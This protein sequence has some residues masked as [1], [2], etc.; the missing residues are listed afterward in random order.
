[1]VTKKPGILEILKV[2]GLIV[3]A[4]SSIIVAYRAIESIPEKAA[5][6]TME[7]VQDI[8][9]SV[10]ELKALIE[11]NA[12]DNKEYHEQM[13]LILTEHGIQLTTLNRKQDNLKEL[14]TTEFAKTMTPEQVRQM[15]L[16]VNE[17]ESK[18]NGTY[19]CPT[20]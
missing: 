16:Y 1:M 7:V 17:V 14:V 2:P 11:V 19:N 9:V 20:P 4:I 3:G 18:K 12:S 6:K 5:A 8:K 15:M 10:D 13:R